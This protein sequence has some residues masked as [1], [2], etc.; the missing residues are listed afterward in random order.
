MLQIYIKT[1]LPVRKDLIKNGIG[2]VPGNFISF[3]LLNL[4]QAK[5]CIKINAV[6]YICFKTFCVIELY[7]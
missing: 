2:Q 3:A 7:F 1:A 4:G 6:C 5:V